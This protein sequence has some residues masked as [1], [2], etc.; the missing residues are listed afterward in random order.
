MPTKTRQRLIEAA[1]KRFYRDG[2]RNVGVDQILDDVRI[3]KTAFYKHFESK[4]DLMLE[5]LRSRDLWLQNYFRDQLRVMAGNEARK[6]LYKLFEVARQ[7]IESDQFNGCIFVNAAM[8]FPLPHDPVHQA[9]AANK[10]A[11]EQIVLELAERAGADD[12]QALSHELCLLLEGAYV[13]S[14]VSGRSDAVD[15]AHR[16]SHD[17][18]DARLPTQRRRPNR[19][20]GSSASLERT[21]RDEVQSSGFSRMGRT[22]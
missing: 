1:I 15:L 5:A 4:D 20:R 17:I 22:H 9:A 6:Q 12:P 2:F 7:L 3:S 16:L 21:G 10:Q 11:I 8:E 18:L 19:A 13:T 14:Q